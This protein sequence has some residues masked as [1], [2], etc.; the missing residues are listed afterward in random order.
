LSVRDTGTG[1]PAS[2]TD[3]LFE[4]FYRIKDGRARSHEGSGIGLALVQELVNLHGGTIGVSSRMGRGSTFRVAIP[5]GRAHLPAD[6]IGA[7]RRLPPTS[8]GAIPFVEE[9]L[10][11]LPAEPPPPGAAAV[12]PDAAPANRL[13]NDEE[14]RGTETVRVLLVDD[15][16]DMRRY[17]LQLLTPHWRASAVADGA[18]ALNAIQADPPDLVLADVMMPGMDGF[19]LLQRLRSAPDTRN[20]PVILLSARAGEEARIDGMGAG[21]DDYLTKPFS[22]RELIARVRAHLKLARLRRKTREA[23]Q[24]NER[25][26]RTVIQNLPGSAVYL[27][28]EEMR[29]IL[30]EGQALEPIGFSKDALEGKRVSDLDDETRAILEPRYRR[31][32]AGESQEYE[33]RFRGRVFHSHY[34]PLRQGDG[35]IRMGLVAA[36]DITERKR[37]E[38]E[39]RRLNENLEQQVAERTELAEARSRQLQ[40]LAVEL[41]EAEEG[42]R[43]RIANLLH[44]DLQQLLASAKLQLQTAGRDLPENRVLGNVGQL[45][46]TAIEKTRSLSHELSPSMLHHSGLVPALQWLVRKVEAQFGLTVEL[47][48]AADRDFSHVPLKEFLFRV[49]QELLFNA[50]KHAGVTTA[51]VQLSG[52]DDRIIVTVSDGGKGFDPAILHSPT[53]RSGLGLLSIRERVHSL[54]GDLHIESAPGSGSRFTLTVPFDLPVLDDPTPPLM[55]ENRA[56][57]APTGPAPY[58]AQRTIRVLF[59]DDHQV[60]RQGLISMIEDQPGIEV[61]GEATDGLEALELTR[62]LRPDLVVMDI[63]M[64]EMDGLEATHHITREMPEVRVVG[65]SMY[66]EEEIR[67]AMRDAG[68]ESF[69]S[70]TASPGDLLKAIYGMDRTDR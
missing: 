49:V 26:H 55:A 44:D 2:E 50:F 52:T 19:E 65:L 31:V 15:N 64:P 11:W 6:R 45:L 42:E 66:E 51:R 43:R 17:L 12:E 70:K 68:A 62:Q 59:A 8:V 22:A 32:L 33:T 41:I 47:E 13:P 7:P 29:F 21:A 30:A 69:V 23:L 56:A 20:M 1:I 36:R 34:L 54:G 35:D 46:E 9:A 61:V 57:P 10:R 63:T 60:M 14:R 27:F 18:A 3:H 48:T 58:E 39:L 24:E 5:L 16:A 28:D 38:E 25:L 37:M 4:R 67:R 53:A 40:S